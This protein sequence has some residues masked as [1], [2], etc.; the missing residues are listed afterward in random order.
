MLIKIWLKD[1]AKNLFIFKGFSHLLKK[2]IISIQLND[3]TGELSYT[4]VETAGV[5]VTFFPIC[6]FFGSA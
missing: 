1:D 6:S 5:L 2:I 3:K 4:P